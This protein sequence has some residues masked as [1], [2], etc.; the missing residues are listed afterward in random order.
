MHIY[1]K[2][3]QAFH[4]QR[5]ETERWWSRL[6]VLIVI[7]QLACFLSAIIRTSTNSNNSMTNSFF[8]ISAL[9]LKAPYLQPGCEYK[10]TRTHAFFRNVTYIMSA[11]NI[12]Y[13]V[14]RGALNIRYLMAITAVHVVVSM[15][16]RL[17]F[18]T[19]T[20]EIR[21]HFVVFRKD[22]V[23]TWE[24]LLMVLGMVMTWSV[25]RENQIMTDYLDACNGA[26]NGAYYNSVQPYTELI[27]SYIVS[28]AITFINAVFAIWNLSKENPRDEMLKEDKRRREEWEKAMREYYG[29]PDP[30]TTAAADAAPV[31]A[32]PQVTYA[33]NNAVTVNPNAPPPPP[34]QVA[35]TAAPINTHPHHHHSYHSAIRRGFSKPFAALSHSLRG[36]SHLDDPVVAAQHQQHH[37][38]S[39]SPP[40]GSALQ[41]PPSPQQVLQMNGV[42]PQPQ[43]GPMQVPMPAL[44]PQKQP[45]LQQP[46]QQQ[47]Q[48]QY[49]TSQPV[50]ESP[51]VGP[52]VSR[53]LT[54]LLNEEYDEEE[55]ETR[56]TPQ[57]RQGN[58]NNGTPQQASS[59]HSGRYDIHEVENDDEP[60]DS[61]DVDVTSSSP[62]GPASSSAAG[63]NNN[64]NSG[65]RAAAGSDAS[66][67][68]LNARLATVPPPPPTYSG[69]RRQ[70]Q[71]QQRRQQQQPRMQNTRGQMLAPPSPLQG[72]GAETTDD[73]VVQ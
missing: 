55:E 27:D 42:A 8:A 48:P 40:H 20:H 17:W 47:Q 39:T 70:Q 71:Q 73:T 67:A 1:G 26:S 31:G 7:V 16:N 3:Q 34:A 45:P 5:T 29:L 60:Y 64:G 28:I 50:Q 12:G 65:R 66:T 33:N 24:V 53:P 54:P 4:L 57:T 21:Y 52:S 62:R 72:G 36:R 30:A 56:M 18:E 11:D 10:V 59:S 6:N 69:D 46:P 43:P 38:R 35:P 32:S 41:Q 19:N 15:L 13:F 63:N 9:Q 49:R 25:T 14:S 2:D 44:Q 37:Q 58:N 51:H 22:M 68:L 61:V 23:T